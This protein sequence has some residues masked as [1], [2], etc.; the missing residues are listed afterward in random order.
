MTHTE[1]PDACWEKKNQI[2]D[3]PKWVGQHM[4]EIKDGEIE[5][6]VTF[7]DHNWGIRGLNV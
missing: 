2:F 3:M 6:S 7:P 4:T 1:S 5:A